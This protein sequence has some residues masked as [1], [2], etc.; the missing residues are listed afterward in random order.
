V[1]A[2]GNFWGVANPAQ[3]V[4]DG[5][6][7]TNIPDALPGKMFDGS[8]YIDLGAAFAFPVGGV[9][10]LDLPG[11]VYANL[12]LPH[13]AGRATSTQGSARGAVFSD[14]VGE[15]SPNGL[16]ADVALASLNEGGRSMHHPGADGVVEDV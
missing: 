8:G 10:W 9:N 1:E 11:D 7:N 13:R 16:V 5:K 2:K 6:R 14:H 15:F 12:H 4:R 3:V